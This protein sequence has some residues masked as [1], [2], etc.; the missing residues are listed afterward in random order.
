MKNDFAA[1][2]LLSYTYFYLFAALKNKYLCEEEH[3]KEIEKVL[4]QLSEGFALSAAE[5]A[6]ALS[7]NV[8]QGKRQKD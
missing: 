7:A 2:Q 1:K 3:G 5:D 6:L 4:T 8:S